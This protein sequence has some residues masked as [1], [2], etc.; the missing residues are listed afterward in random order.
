MTPYAQ[1]ERLVAVTPERIAR[2][3][4][5]ANSAGIHGTIGPCPAEQPSRLAENR[6]G[7]QHRRVSADKRGAAS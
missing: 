2:I 5:L 3:D 1:V 7:E 4:I 6:E